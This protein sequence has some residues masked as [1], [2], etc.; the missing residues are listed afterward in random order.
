MI[1]EDLSEY[2]PM[3]VDVRWKDYSL[4][5]IKTFGVAEDKCITDMYFRIGSVTK[6]YVATVILYL[7]EKGNINVKQTAYRY[8]SCIDE[9]WVTYLP[10]DITIEHLA[11]MTS[12]LYN[13]TED[14]DFLKFI[15]DNPSYQFTPGE[16]LSKYALRSDKKIKEKTFSYCNTNYLLLGLVASQVTGKTIEELYEK[17]IF[18]PLSFNRT[19]V[20]KDCG[21]PTPRFEGFMYGYEDERDSNR[22]LRNVTDTNTSWS[23]S[24]GNLISTLYEVGRFIK[25][26]DNLLEERTKMYRD[27]LFRKVG[28]VEYGFGLMRKRD[29]VGHNGNISGFQT[30]V[31]YSIKD[32]VTITLMTNASNKK[33]LNNLMKNILK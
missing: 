31:M 11:T 32:D 23:G 20:P 18:K 3:T 27:S 16:L 12:G 2:G 17:I 10:K 28:D 19:F 5:S 26:C 22:E 4:L 7:Y 1:E 33:P 14:E 8:L 29:W 30:F 15:T 24:A 21:I 25:E 13:Y 6:V 9:E